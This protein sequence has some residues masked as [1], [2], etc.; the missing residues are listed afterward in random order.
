MSWRAF[1]LDLAVPLPL[2]LLHMHYL[3]EVLKLAESMLA[4]TPLPPSSVRP[5]DLESVQ[6]S[7]LAPVV[8]DTVPFAAHFG[9][10]VVDT[11][12]VYRPG[13]VVEATFR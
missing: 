11:Q 5:P 8:R 6:I 4:G 1:A 12:G 7:L 13:Q 2:T 10:V 3:Q 9:D